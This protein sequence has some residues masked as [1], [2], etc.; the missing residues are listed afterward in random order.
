MELDRQLGW[1]VLSWRH[2][3]GDDVSELADRWQQGWVPA[4]AECAAAEEQAG[5][6]RG[7]LSSLID[8][9]RIAEADQAPA[10]QRSR[11]PAPDRS[12]LPELL[13]LA[14]GGH[15]T[16]AHW[17]D[18]GAMLRADPELAP[19]GQELD[20]LLSHLANALPRGVKHAY[21]LM[22]CAALDLASLPEVRAPMVAAIRDCVGDPDGPSFLETI[23]LLEQ[24][25]TPES[26][27]LLLD[28]LEQTPSRAQRQYAAEL[29]SEAIARGEFSEAERSRVLL[30]VLTS[31]RSDPLVA[32]EDLGQLI[33]VLPLGLASALARDERVSGAVVSDPMA[34][35][36]TDE[37]HRWSHA[38]A[39][40]A[41]GTWPAGGEH[42]E[43]SLAEVITQCLFVRNAE[44]RWRAALTLSASPFQVG[45]ADGL[46]GL[47]KRP[48]VPP[49][50]RQ[51]AAKALSHVVSA[52]STLQMVPLL[53]DPDPA[54]AERVTMAYGHTTFSE[55][56]DQVLR[57]RIPSTAEPLG[58]ACVYAL[59][60]TGSPGIAVL[61][62]S[63]HAPRWQRHTA[64]WWHETG[65]AI[66]A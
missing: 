38:L 48:G 56:A 60:M 61:V 33:D 51:R 14:V 32:R 24:I 66:H 59:G 37:A 8:L 46:T 17:R 16:A 35:M 45:L 44:R 7:R 36:E 11:W 42:L 15:A 63:Q 39:Q 2:V 3:T 4:Y 54:V 12:Q 40:R 23:G 53:H 41:L 25:P 18:L 29:A 28:L 10:A 19:K 31:W 21:R 30:R 52:G 49:G 5:L 1:L 58:R 55:T 50:L 57:R 13:E 65:S 64:R 43:S 22:R 47:L 27:R 34:G 6:A 9:V 26:H 62:E 20:A